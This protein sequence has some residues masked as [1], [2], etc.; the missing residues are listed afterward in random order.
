M[1]SGLEQPMQ[2]LFFG[3]P[4]LHNHTIKI[5]ITPTTTQ[6]QPQSNYTTTLCSAIIAGA[7]ML[8][9]IFID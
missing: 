5:T 9:L 4:Q 7:M 8:P 1:N 6:S 2:S 3:A